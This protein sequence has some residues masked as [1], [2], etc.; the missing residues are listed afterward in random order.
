MS[1]K[2][3][4]RYAA[5]HEQEHAGLTD[6]QVEIGT[7]A[8]LRDLLTLRGEGITKLIVEIEQAPALRDVLLGHGGGPRPGMTRKRPGCARCAGLGFLVDALEGGIVGTFEC[9]GSFPCPDCD[10]TGEAPA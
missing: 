9:A 6:E 7:G 10:G 2:L 5:G 1:Y 3:T 8:F 4:V